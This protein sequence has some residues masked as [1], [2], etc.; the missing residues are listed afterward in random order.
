M[1]ATNWRSWGS[2][3]PSSEARLMLHAGAGSIAVAE[4]QA[5]PAARG[6]AELSTGARLWLLAKAGGMAAAERPAEPSEGGE[7]TLFREGPPVLYVAG[8]SVLCVLC[9]PPMPE[10]R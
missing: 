4:E 3:E 9:I 8:S 1:F 5:D 7:A 6:E 2:A 10:R